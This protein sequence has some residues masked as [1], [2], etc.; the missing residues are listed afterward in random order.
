MGILQW[1]NGLD[2]WLGSL[3]FRLRGE[4]PPEP[5]VV[6]VTVDRPSEDHLRPL[7]WSD[8]VWA[9]ALR[10]INGAR[11]SAIALDVPEW[12]EVLAA[13]QS[14]L[15]TDLAQVLRESPIVLSLAV[16]EGEGE[17][18]EVME[19]LGGVALEAGGLPQLPLEQMHLSVAPVELLREARGIGC[20]SIY[21]DLDGVVR[22]VPLLVNYKNSVFPSLALEA[23]RV[24]QKLPARSAKWTGTGV[25]MGEA[26]I[27]TLSTGEMLVNYAGGY[28][29]YPQVPFYSV[30]EMSGEEL[31]ERFGGK[32]VLIGP[33]H[34]ETAVFLRTPTAARLP[35]LEVQANALG[36][37]LRGDYLRPMPAL[38]WLA[39]VLALCLLTGIAVTGRNIGVA[40]LITA[41]LAVVVWIALFALFRHGI[42]PSWSGALLGVL[43]TGA[44]LLA[45]QAGIS[46]QD[47]VQAEL[48]LQSRLG[49]IAGIGRLIDSSLDRQQLLDQTMHWVEDELDVEACSLLLL[50]EKTNR[51]R[52]EV[53]LGPK[54]DQAKDFTLEIGEGI[55][56]LVAKSGEPIIINN[57]RQDPRKNQ[58]IARAIDYQLEKVLCVPMTLH[59]KVIGVIE[60]MNKRH[61]ADF[62]QHDA[63]LLTVIAQQASMFLENARLY[64]VLQDR[65]DYANAELLAAMRELRAQKARVETLVEEMVDGVMSVD[66]TGKIVLVN[67]VARRMLG[68]QGREVEGERLEVVVAQPQIAAL[69]SLPL[70]QEA[71]SVSEEVA[72]GGD[73]GQV[74]RVT[75]AMIEGAAGEQAGKCAVLTDV[76]HFKQLDQMKTDLVSF[77]SHELKTPLTS[78]GLY[79][80]MLKEKLKEQKIDEAQDM[81][82]AIDRQM[83]RMKHMVEDFLNV[84]RIEQGRPLDMLW[85]EIT[86]VRA[87]VEEVVNIEA[88]AS[89]DHEISLDMPLQLP[90]LWADRGK[91]E[92]VF[93]NLVNNA[94]KYSPDG[95]L[96]S[97][98]AEQ[99]GDMM[100]FSVAD[101]GLGISEEERSRLFQRFARAQADQ[102]RISGTGLGLFVCKALI[103]AHGGRIWLESTPGKGST[104]YFTVP[105]YR[106]Q[107][108]ET[109]ANAD[110]GKA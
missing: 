41:I 50:D 77:V 17:R 55:V 103:E 18:R 95:G 81:A 94:I 22:S 70:S 10:R 83:I 34:G 58:D 25:A 76:T 14:G 101:M 23:L 59:G 108:K 35:G 80:H 21:P 5:H 100:Q 75:V 24:G 87:F 36:S 67:S 73:D 48:R 30:L 64:G 15:M 68:L 105:V 86:N 7:P 109:K 13:P 52:F 53:A 16:V 57:A 11:P 12:D 54:G 28:R 90:S 66:G 9:E 60:A 84:S 102:R 106:G 89:R 49:A 44:T 98:R 96:I 4:L 82:A 88:R 91:V 61:N 2:N 8:A 32:Y 56:G 62:T 29:C 78:I 107:D 72:L 27:P 33:V 19:V 26:R 104:F 69:F 20:I 93:I 1:L 31:K 37:L 3:A 79:G 38:V 65:V 92:E 63:S 39:I 97:I 46:D 99:Q 110:A 85:H 74:V 51:L 6:M 42:W 40:A 71:P 47:K 45:R 43:L